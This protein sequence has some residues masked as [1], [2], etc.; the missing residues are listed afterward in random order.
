[1]RRHGLQLPLCDVVTRRWDCGRHRSFCG[2]IEVSPGQGDTPPFQRLRVGF[3][4]IQS[5]RIIGNLDLCHVVCLFDNNLFLVFCS[6][7]TVRSCERGASS[8]IRNLNAGQRVVE[9]T[10]TCWFQS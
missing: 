6:C 4:I 5:L 9:M 1:M 2:E 7:R 3:I 8:M 10:A